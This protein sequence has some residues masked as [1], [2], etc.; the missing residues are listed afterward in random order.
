MP[1]IESSSDSLPDTG[2][3]K[4]FLIFY[5]SRDDGDRMW[6]PDCRDVEELVQKSFNDSSEKGFVIYVGQ[7]AEWKTPENKY[8]LSHNIQSIPTIARLEDGKETG[9]LVENEI[10]QPG[11]LEKFISA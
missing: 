11:N 3:G 8:R 10:L 2:S 1:L 6:C 4:S 7:R 9:R 5:S